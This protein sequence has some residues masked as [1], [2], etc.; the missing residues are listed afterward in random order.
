M[1]RVLVGAIVCAG[2]AIS[3]HAQEEWIEVAKSSASS[4][5]IKL[6]TLTFKRNKAEEAIVVGVGRS[7][8]IK[9]R[10]VVIEQWYVRTDDC[11]AELGKLVTLSTDGTYLYENDFVFDGGNV[12]SAKAE[13]LCTFYKAVKENA[14]KKGI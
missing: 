7:V 5:S 9:T 10:A 8:D 2:V 14:E 12:A 13:S 4:F 11:D 1:K 6:S 3:A